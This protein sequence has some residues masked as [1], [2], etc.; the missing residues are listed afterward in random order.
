MTIKISA[1][2]LEQMIYGINC[3]QQMSFL[4]MI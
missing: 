4:G 3:Q 2:Y 1:L